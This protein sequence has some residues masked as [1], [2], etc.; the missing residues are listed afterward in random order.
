[1]LSRR[2]SDQ[3]GPTIRVI[4]SHSLHRRC[5]NFLRTRLARR[6]ADEKIPPDFIERSQVISCGNKIA[7]LNRWRARVHD[8]DEL[9][10]R[11][12]ARNDG[13]V[14]GIQHPCQGSF[15]DSFDTIHCF[16]P[17][18]PPTHLE[19][20][21]ETCW[22]F[23]RAISRGLHTPDVSH[24]AAIP[25]LERRGNNPRWYIKEFAGRL[26]VWPIKFSHSR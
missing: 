10:H 12:G 22:S 23:S 26:T 9:P 2:S 24:S 6:F 19:C 13:D 8:D 20:R 14:R 21:V 4:L 3:S 7:R 25:R 11:S 5:A 16:L 18:P 15:D 17:L 1:M